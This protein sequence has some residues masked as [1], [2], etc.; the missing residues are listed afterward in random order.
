[1][2]KPVRIAFV[3]EGPTD[4]I[5]LKAA[6]RALLNGRDFEQTDIW[7]ELDESLRPTTE[8]GWG[9]VYKWCRQVVE[10]VEGEAARNNPLFVFNDIVIIHVDA[11]VA[12]KSYSDYNIQD[13]PKNDLPCE[14]ECPPPTATTDALRAVILGWLNE[15]SVLPKV[16]FCTPSKSSDTWVLVAAF[17]DDG[18]AKRA[19][20]ECRGDVEVRLRIHG[21]IKSGQKLIGRY[22][23]QGRAIQQ[24]WPLVRERCSEAERFSIDFLASAQGR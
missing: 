12:R 7:P 3:M 13:A 22:D 24:S 4:Y 5:V 16:V 9:A 11:D 1:M 23:S 19:D 2:S 15:A 17:P 14:R 8:G 21:L 18:T 10:Q 20:I 6:I